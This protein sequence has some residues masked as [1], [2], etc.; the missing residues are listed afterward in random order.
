M[1]SQSIPSVRYEVDSELG[2]CNCF[3][4]QDG[5]F[6]KHQAA[7]VLHFGAHFPNSSESTC[8]SRHLAAILAVG[9]ANCHPK[10]Y[11]QALGEEIA[12]TD[13]EISEELSNLP[14]QLVDD[15]V[16]DG[17]EEGAV[18]SE[19]GQEVDDEEEARERENAAPPSSRVR[20]R[21][22]AH[23]SFQRGTTRVFRRPWIASFGKWAL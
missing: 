6:C 5:K 22:S 16:E 17:A 4:G 21:T 15:S 10:E 8:Y 1:P 7:V 19:V 20:Q 9:K 11:Y 13:I 2:I 18:E 12:F 3:Q 23:S 14:L